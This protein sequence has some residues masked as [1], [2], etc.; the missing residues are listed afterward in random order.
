MENDAAPELYTVWKEARNHIAQGNYDRAIEI[1][2]YILIRYDDNNAA[3]EYT[4]AYLGDI[5]L[6]LRQLEQAEVH[7]KR[8][9]KYSPMNHHYHYLLGFTYSVGRQWEKAIEEFELSLEQKPDE[10]EY[11]RGLGWAIRSKGNKTDGFKYLH[12]AA[13]LAPRNVNI[14]T[15]LAVA[16][17]SDFEFDKAREYAEK[18]IG[19]D[20]S[21]N[22]AREVLERVD[23]FEREYRGFDA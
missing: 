19:F 13:E 10:A 12:Q 4:N 23:R 11:L 5:Y 21:S 2:K 8:A 18:A 7:L 15:D 22:I 16:Y 20:P 6:T 17:L 9:I 14:L 1:Y 3:V